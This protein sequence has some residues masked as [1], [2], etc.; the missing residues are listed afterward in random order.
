LWCFNVFVVLECV[1]GADNAQFG[2]VEKIQLDEASTDGVVYIH[3]KSVLSALNV[4][5]FGRAL[6]PVLSDISVQ[7]VN[8]FA[9]GWQYRDRTIRARYYDERKFHAGMLEH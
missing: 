1:C 6:L 7:A 2:P 4:S 8:R 3:F 5:V 9:E